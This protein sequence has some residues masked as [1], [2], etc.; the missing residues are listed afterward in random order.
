MRISSLSFTTSSLPG[1]M[2]NQS[3][4]ARLNQQIASTQKYLSPQDNPLAARQAMT[5]SSSI[6]RDTQ[7]MANQTQANQT[8]SEESTVLQGMQSALQGVSQLLTT[9]TGNMTQAQRKEE[10]TTLVNYYMQIKDYANSQ[11]TS[12]NYLFAG[13]N[14]NTQPYQNAMTYPAIAATQAT[15][16]TGTADGPQLSSQGVRSANISNG[17]SVQVSDNL[18]NV[19][20][21]SSPVSIP[22][23]AAVVHAT[24]P[25]TYTTT[26]VGTK[27]VFQAIDQMAIALSDPNLTGSQVQ[28]AMGVAAGAVNTALST[29]QT[30]QSRV[31]VAQVQISDTQAN[32]K[33]RM[34]VS[35]NALSD[36]TQVDQAAA[37]V[38]MQTRQTSLQ[39]AMTAFAQT[40]KLSMFNYM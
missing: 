6:A 4:I 11:D 23:S 19:I 1:I 16:Y 39:A 33:S 31:A 8:L 32:T 24:I 14:S 34:T 7:Y 13:S 2:D 5:L 25:P 17:G 40:S 38:E 20:Q 12:G 18:Q 15:T 27:D 9:A 3:S 29:L 21:F 26:P 30:V 36:L 22:Y 35:Q 37:I 28:K 10:A